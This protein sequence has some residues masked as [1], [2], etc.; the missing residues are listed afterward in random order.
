[1]RFALIS[2]LVLAACGGSTSEGGTG[3]SSSGGSSSGGSSSGGASSGGSSSGGAG[4][5]SGGGGSGNA[6][7]LGGSAGWFACK[8]P[9]ECLLYPTNCCG[10]CGP[11]A[12][13]GYEAVN[14]AHAKDYVASTCADPVACPD[15]ITYEEPNYLALC[16]NGTCTEVDL[17]LDALSA[18]G[19][20][21]DC[22]LRYG[23]DCCESCGGGALVA[24]STKASLA[25]EVCSPF[26]GA[27][28]PC[29][30]PPYPANAA[31]VC[32]AGHCAVKY[33]GL[34]GP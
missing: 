31:A 25:A 6:G 34:G 1:M 23:T 27:C 22:Q 5:V 8:D 15:C 17:R 28:P 11:A 9:G 24:V 12:L 33:S 19:S 26:G 16:R 3:G 13:S 32:Q 21:G 2:C 30:P 4:A 10:Y 18:C 20:D 7:G 29:M 14:Q